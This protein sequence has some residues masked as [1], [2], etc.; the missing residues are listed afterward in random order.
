MKIP[1]SDQIHEATR[2]VS[3]AK[4]AAEINPSVI[5]RLDA[6]ESIVVTLQTYQALLQAG[7]VR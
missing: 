5:P 2:W 4:K 3:S 6:A 1:L 7:H